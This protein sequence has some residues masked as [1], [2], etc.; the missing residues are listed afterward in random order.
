MTLG[1][2][3]ITQGS[4][5]LLSRTERRT[6]VKTLPEAFDGLMA[7]VADT[8]TVIAE[9]R[10][11][12]SLRPSVWE[13]EGSDGTRWFAK[14][15]VGPKL[16]RR[17]VEAYQKWVGALG[18]DRAP[19]LVASDAEARTVLVTAVPGASLDRLR[20]PAEQERE[21]YRQA[22]LLLA[23]LH[24]ADTWQ[25]S[26]EA[27]E[28][29]WDEA[30]AKLLDNAA[31]LV[32]AGDIA[33]LRSLAQQ[34]PVGLTRVASQGDYMPKNWMWEEHEQ[35]L[36]VVD[37]ERTQLESAAR[38]DLSRLHYRVLQQRPDLAAA[39]YTGYGRPLSP[40]ELH[41][42][43]AYASLDALDSVCWGVTHRDIDLVDEAH[44][45]ITNLRAECTS[46]SQGR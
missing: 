33:L 44:T 20:L 24:A 23:R 8:Y 29:D 25:P 41:A 22:G 35:R 27:V 42:R 26:S 9:H 18:P 11:P 21:A 38:R 5:W 14:Q 28:E 4:S 15:H 13:I 2:E 3:M 31:H 17:E 45:M 32:T 16:H 40:E 19:A 30:L 7:T 46:R 12:V 37:F 1:I 6:A 39:F 36:R 43:M 10:R 34:A